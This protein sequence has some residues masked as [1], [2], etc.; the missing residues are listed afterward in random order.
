M[1]SN[2]CSAAKSIGK[3]LDQPLTLIV[4][5]TI[6]KKEFPAE[7]VSHN[8]NVAVVGRSCRRGAFSMLHLVILASKIGCEFG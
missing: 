1:G 3:T 2:L 8:V 4:G 7:G 5:R 6:G